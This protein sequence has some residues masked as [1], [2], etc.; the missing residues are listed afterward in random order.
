MAITSGFTRPSSVGPQLVKLEILTSDPFIGIREEID[1]A[2]TVK[3]FFDV[4]EVE[5]ISYP[6]FFALA[7]LDES[8]VERKK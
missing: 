3:M 6:S 8:L 2:P 5:M 7:L 1:A 4:P